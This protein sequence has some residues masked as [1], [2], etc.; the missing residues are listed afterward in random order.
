LAEF[1]PLV[2]TLQQTRPF[3]DLLVR[4]L[5]RRPLVGVHPHWT[6]DT[7]AACDLAG[8]NWMSF[9]TFLGGLAPQMFEIGLPISYAAEGACVTLLTGDMI[10]NLGKS[11]T[12]EILSRGA[13]M[14]ATA[15]TALNEAGY[16]DLTGLRV[17]RSLARDC[18]EKFTDHPLNGDFADRARDCRQS[19]NH[20]PASVLEAR[21]PAVETL[22]RLIDYEG[23]TVAPCTMAVFENQRG[24]RICVAGYFPWTF[25]HSLA[26]ASQMKSVLRWL[27]KDQLAAYV[28]SYHKM[29]LWVRAPEAGSIAVAVTNASFDAATNAVLMLRT[30]LRQI[31]V[32]DMDCRETRIDASGRDGPYQKFVLPRVGPWEMRLVVGGPPGSGS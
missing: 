5:G 17:V 27:A 2:Q 7:A 14:D 21:V 30:D 3:Y 23:R 16:G 15:L 12:L 11:Q 25:V 22:S 20:W 28:A 31:R 9:Q 19:F 24:G 8:G 18:S 32:W 10:P 26:K 29:N 1:E 6:K 13:Y 4:H